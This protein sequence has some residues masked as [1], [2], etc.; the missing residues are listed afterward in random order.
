[1]FI[2]KALLA[3]SLLC[4]VSGPRDM[5]VY[6]L[7][8]TSGWDLG[9][10]DVLSAPPSHLPRWMREGGFKVDDHISPTRVDTQNRYS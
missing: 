1:M 9:D 7:Y 3:F 6:L 8:D 5:Y 2:G 4:S 10:D